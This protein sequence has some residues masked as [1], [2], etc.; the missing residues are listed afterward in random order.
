MESL[1]EYDR[2]TILLKYFNIVSCDELYKNLRGIYDFFGPEYGMAKNA[3]LEEARDKIVELLLKRKK[4]SVK[5]F[6]RGLL[7]LDQVICD[8]DL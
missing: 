8:R 1:H 4:V 7:S 2:E 5:G 6:T 3:S